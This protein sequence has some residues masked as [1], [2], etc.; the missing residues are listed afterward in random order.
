MKIFHL[1]PTLGSSGGGVAEAVSNIAY[2]QI[3][4]GLPV[5]VFE[6]KKEPEYRVA[7]SDNTEFDIKFQSFKFTFFKFLCALIEYAPDI[8]HLH[9]VWLPQTPVIM[10]VSS[11]LNRQIM[12]SPHGSFQPGSLKRGWLK[13]RLAKLMWIDILAKK[14]VFCCASES[15]AQ[16]V[17]ALYPKSRIMVSSFGISPLCETRH[18]PIPIIANLSSEIKMFACIARLHPGKGILE[19]IKAFSK[20]HSS[21]NGK[22]IF[23]IAG[24]GDLKYRQAINRFIKVNGLNE[25]VLLVGH[26]NEASKYWLLSKANFSVLPSYG[27]NFGFS[28]LESLAVGTPVLTS[29]YTPWTELDLSKGCLCVDLKP[30]TLEHGLKKMMNLDCLELSLISQ[31]AKEFVT[32]NFDWIDVVK[33]LNVMMKKEFGYKDSA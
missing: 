6:F 24:D 15:E 21:V 7:V 31:A 25:S 13:K 29:I 20:I 14:A 30:E 8:I 19:I 33:R 12:I 11:L 32:R 18:V 2:C 3:Y 17:R 10:M 26:I 1:V 4:L 16:A 5:K 23:V 28:V 9:S 27:E 22:W